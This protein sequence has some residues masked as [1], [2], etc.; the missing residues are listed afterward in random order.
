MI[1]SGG[2]ISKFFSI[3]NSFKKEDLPWKEFLEGM[4][5]SIVKD[6]LPIQFVESMWLK[7][8]VLHL[9]PN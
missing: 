4:G 8:L 3:K 1:M 9:C 5:L 7:R 6:N 2:S